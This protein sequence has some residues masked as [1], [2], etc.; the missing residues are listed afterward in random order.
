LSCADGP[1][2]ADVWFPRRPEPGTCSEW[3]WAHEPSNTI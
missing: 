2:P 1:A 3:Y